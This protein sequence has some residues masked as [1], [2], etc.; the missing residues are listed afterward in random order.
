MTHPWAI[1][2]LTWLHTHTHTH[3]HTT[4]TQ[5]LKH[6]H[7]RMTRLLS[8]YQARGKQRKQLISAIKDITTLFALSNTMDV[9][10]G[11]WSRAENNMMWR[12]RVCTFMQHFGRMEKLKKRA[13]ES[14]QYNAHR[15]DFAFCLFDAMDVWSYKECSSAYSTGAPPGLHPISLHALHQ[16]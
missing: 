15:D 7:R 8:N 12:S 6:T 9:C 5:Q 13:L 1:H 14:E 4:H 16:L 2:T 3:T 11:I 10:R